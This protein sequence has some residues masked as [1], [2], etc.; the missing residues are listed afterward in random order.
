MGV[1]KRDH[2]RSRP[3]LLARL[4]FAANISFHILFPTISIGLCWLLLDFR[5]R[6]AL[7]GDRDWESDDRF[8]RS[9]LGCQRDLDLARLHLADVPHRSTVGE[10]RP[11]LGVP[12]QSSYV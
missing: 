3:L 1:R 10:P 8:H 5:T 4:Q 9:L 2:V 6:F 11:P 7:T 12:A